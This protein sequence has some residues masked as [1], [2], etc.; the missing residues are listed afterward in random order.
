MNGEK[1]N[2]RVTE[3][4][5]IVMLSRNAPITDEQIYWAGSA[6]RAK[7][8]MRKQAEAVKKLK[9]KTEG[10]QDDK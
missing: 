8:R 7:A 5:F 1:V 9:E 4:E 3:A 6:E 10:K 2:K